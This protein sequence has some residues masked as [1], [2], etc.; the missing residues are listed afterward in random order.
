MKELLYKELS[1]KIIGAAMEVHKIL[2]QGFLE[3]V[4]E[5]ALAYEFK[6]ENILF[7][8]QKTLQVIYKDIIAKEYIADF[9][10][11][12]KI[13]IEIKAIK[14]LTESEE[15]QLQNYLKATGI[16]IGF[17]LNFGEKSLKFKR[18]IRTTN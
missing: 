14:G 1:Y 5:E 18:I 12:S 8:R 3:A 11:D 13:I 16:K 2:G 7:E 9:L 17:L 10:I 4:Y 15:A 6:L